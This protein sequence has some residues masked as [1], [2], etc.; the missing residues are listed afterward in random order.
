MHDRS[1]SL[2]FSAM[3]FVASIAAL[4][5]TVRVATHDP[6][7]YGSTMHH[8]YPEHA[9]AQSEIS[10]V[11]RISYDRLL[12]LYPELAGK[13]ATSK[14]RL[15]GMDSRARRF[16]PRGPLEVLEVTDT[17]GRHLIVLE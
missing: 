15:P 5:L 7:S 10:S 2:I 4:T 13:E 14:S 8:S 12:H 16:P 17:A 11:T 1:V 6:C 9:A 3:A